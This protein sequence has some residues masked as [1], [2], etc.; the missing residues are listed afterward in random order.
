MAR[1]TRSGVAFR[2]CRSGSSP[3]STS[4][5]STISMIGSPGLG[6]GRAIVA[7]TIYGVDALTAAQALS[8]I[9]YLLRQDEKERFRAKAFSAAAWSIALQKPD[10]EA[11]HA[12]G[13]LTSIEG[14]GEGIA[15]VLDGFI[16]TGESRYLNRLRE[17]M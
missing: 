4:S 11:L 5:D 10:L 7:H 9:G 16:E 14:V 15:R 8:E 2:P 6:S 12:A 3:S 13:R 17:Q 1:E